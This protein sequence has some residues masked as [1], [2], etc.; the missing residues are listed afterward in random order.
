MATEL[1][2]MKTGQSDVHISKRWI[3]RFLKRNNQLKTTFSRALNNNRVKATHPETIRRWFSLLTRII[4][5][6]EIQKES[7]FNFNEKDVLINITSAMKII[8]KVKDHRRFKTQSG[9]RE[10]ITIIEAVNAID[11]AISPT[12]VFKEKH[13]RSS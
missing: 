5:E 7:I 13:Y 11:W 3:E 6:Y 9:N 1:L 2:Q 4:N 10:L 12:L 8:K